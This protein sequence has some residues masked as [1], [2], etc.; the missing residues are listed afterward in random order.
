M[1]QPKMPVAVTMGEPAG[2]GPDVALMAWAAR[3]DQSLPPF[4]LRADPGLLAHRAQRLGLSVPIQMVE[5]EDAVATFGR[6]LPV[7]TGTHAI[8]DRPGEETSA[9]A[10]DVIRSIEA[11]VTD[12]RDGRAI[13]ILTNPINKANLYSAGFDHPGHTEFLGALAE[14]YW[15]PDRPVKPVMMIAG[16]DLMVVP[17]TIHIALKDVPS[18]LTEELIVET[19]RIVAGDLRQRF[20]LPAPRLALCGLNPHAGENGTMGT[21]DRDVIAPAVARLQA[22]GIDAFGPLPADTMFHARARETYDC[23]IGMY[24][25]Q[26]L[27]PAKTLGFDDAVNVTLG[28]PFVR[29]SPDHGTAYGIAG[30]GK[31]KPDSFIAALRMAA[32]LGNPDA[33]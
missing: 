23:A 10:Q 28:L 14:R 11:C 26:V 6:A 13:A 29:T 32:I 9:T 24:H 18:A 1:S 3:K 5:P 22:E 19:V 4:Y 8:E 16:P 31:A 2:I 15:Q 7:V 21:E 30:T 33:L 20:G 27:V 17:V 12:V 25:D